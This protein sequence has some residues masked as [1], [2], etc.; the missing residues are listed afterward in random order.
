MTAPLL[1][2]ADPRQDHA[3][4]RLAAEPIVWLTTVGGDARPHS[5]PVW[6]LFTDPEIVLFSRPDTAK[7]GRLRERPGVSLTLDTAAAGTDVVLAE[8]DAMLAGE[9]SP[10]ELKAFGEKY[11][12][13]LGG[14]DL[15]GW[16]QVFAQPI[17]VRLHRIV[18]WHAGPDGL[19]RIV[20]R[21]H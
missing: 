6:F 9:P 19:E 5:V 10:T 16:R 17:R 7:V 3:A 20:A 12:D 15:D 8:G 1:D 11:R 14:Q 13:M 21:P 4:A 2:P 18:A